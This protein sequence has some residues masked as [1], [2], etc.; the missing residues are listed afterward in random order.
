MLLNASRPYYPAVGLHFLPG[1]AAPFFFFHH[2]V[3]CEGVTI[4]FT[5]ALSLAGEDAG[6]A[7]QAA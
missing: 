6:K 3:E 1:N 5:Y 4:G 2:G 7:E